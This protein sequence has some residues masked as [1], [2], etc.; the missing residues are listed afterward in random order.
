MSSDIPGDRAPYL[1]ICTPVLPEHPL[2]MAT[3]TPGNEQEKNQRL[4]A[5]P[6]LSRNNWGRTDLAR[7][8]STEIDYAPYVSPSS[9]RRTTESR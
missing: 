5:M 1:N 8:V 4:N 6:R 7:M 3:R 2:S 9:P